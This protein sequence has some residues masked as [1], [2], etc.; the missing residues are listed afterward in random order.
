[1]KPTKTALICLLVAI[2]L[3]ACRSSNPVAFRQ[4]KKAIPLAYDAGSRTYYTW[5]EDYLRYFDTNDI[6]TILKAVQEKAR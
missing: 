1:M 5:D 4:E 2:T 3:T 6:P